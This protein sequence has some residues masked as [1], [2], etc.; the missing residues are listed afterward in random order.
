MA[1]DGPRAS[2]PPVPRTG[3]R[4]TS[5]LRRPRDQS[6]EIRRH[7]PLIAWARAVASAPACSCRLAAAGTGCN[8]HRHEM[9]TARRGGCPPDLAA[10]D[11][12]SRTQ[13]PPADHPHS[14]TNVSGGRARDDLLVGAALATVYY[15]QRCPRRH[16]HCPT[17]TP[18]KTQEPG[19]KMPMFGV[20]RRS[21]V[22]QPRE[23]ASPGSPLPM[24]GSQME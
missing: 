9:P 16:G 4:G 14:A 1:R 10:G 24:R 21:L 8:L 7:T 11:P 22:V 15:R 18:V 3:P 23:R 12:R 17:S 2:A 5:L 20:A 19:V 13:F 6:D